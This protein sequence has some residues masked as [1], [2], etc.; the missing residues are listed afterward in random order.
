MAVPTTTKGGQRPLTMKDLAQAFGAPTNKIMWWEGA[1]K[2]PKANVDR[3][4]RHSWNVKD[5]Q[6]WAATEK[7][8]AFIDE[9][10]P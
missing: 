3:Q 7:G 1:G 10:V 9:L 4:G 8:R 5:I 2:L 6:A